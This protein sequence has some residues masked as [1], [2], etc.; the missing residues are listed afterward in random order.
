MGS[1]AQHCMTNPRK[2]HVRFFHK[3]EGS[4]A[5]EAMV[6][7]DVA[8]TQSERPA[9]PCRVCTHVRVCMFL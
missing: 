4:K 1:Q 9:P 8:P 6:R 2:K 5:M 3:K 7:S